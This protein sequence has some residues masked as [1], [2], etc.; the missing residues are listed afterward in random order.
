MAF[1]GRSLERND[2]G[3]IRVEDAIAI[4]MTSRAGPKNVK[5]FAVIVFLVTV[6]GV[7]DMPPVLDGESSGAGE[8]D[9]KAA[10]L[11]HFAQFVEWPAESFK[12]A[13]SPLTYCTIGEDP[14][15]GALDQS[16]NGKMVGTRPLRVA[17]IQQS[18]SVQSCQVL[19]VGAGVAK[20]LGVAIGSVA[21]NGILLVGETEHFVQEGGVIGFLLEQN[22]LRFE[23]N[24]EAAEKANL[25]I[26]A[27]LLT[28]A[29]T[30]IGAP[31]RD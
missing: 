14:F 7:L 8:Y 27:R 9:V 15:H 29:R 10:F 26:S 31:P 3:R 12:D 21:G 25:K 23:I 5:R 16:L 11:F 22:K 2:E 17:H 18:Q 30:V 6:S 24:L 1:R 28:L 4:T 19:F 13:S 20:R